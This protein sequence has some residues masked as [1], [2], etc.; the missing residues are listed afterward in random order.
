MDD[1]KDL[2]ERMDAAIRERVEKALDL[3]R[4]FLTPGELEEHRR[5][6]TF[7]A[8]TTPARLEDQRP[9]VVPDRSGTEIK[10]GTLGRILTEELSRYPPSEQRMFVARMLEGAE[11]EDV[12]REGGV[13]VSTAKRGVAAMRGRILVRLRAR[14]VS[15][16]RG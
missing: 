10:P 12:G 16:G 14:G 13:S 15:D 2:E 5:M 3:T 11:W 7:L 9:R 1:P 4:D 8:R 6:L